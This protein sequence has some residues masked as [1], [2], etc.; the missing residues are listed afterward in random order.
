MSISASSAPSPPSPRP[1]IAVV[2]AGPAG[3]TAAYVLAKAGAQVE[4]HEGSRVV[5]GLSRTLDLWNQRVDL[6]P[7]RFHT[8]DAR[9][10]SL[11][12][13]VVG[14]DWATVESHP[15][16]F[17]NDGKVLRYPLQVVDVVRKVGL[18]ESIRC[19]L[20]YGRQQ[21][22]PLP[23]VRTFEDWLVQHFGRRV[24]E[25]FFRD[26][27]EKFFGRPCSAVDASVS[28]AAAKD[29]SLV[30]TV[31]AALRTGASNARARA[32]KQVTEQF[33]YP[34]RGTGEVYERMAQFVRDHGG[35]VLLESRVEALEVEGRRVTGLKSS[36]GSRAY[37]YIISSAPLVPLVAQLPGQP[38][39]VQRA[40]TEARDVLTF[41]SAL[42]VY[43]EVHETGLFP[44]SWLEMHTRAVRTC[45]VTNFRNW[46]PGLYGEER[47]TIL[48][49][50]YWCS[51]DE[52]LWSE[53]DEAMAA[54]AR[55]ELESVGLLGPAPVGRFH[56]VRLPRCYP[57]YQPGFQRVLQP[58]QEHLDN[59]ERL[60]S[61]GR[62]G[63]FSYN[64]QDA[65][66][67]MGLEAADGARAALGF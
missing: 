1:R 27:N 19:V 13:S 54:L 49:A 63:R 37:D 2:G 64:S 11:W 47:S 30:D 34:Q 17:R 24:Y 51:Q 41:R 28:G 50:E 57:V 42:L 7:H 9:I 65:N 4:V 60:S 58:L 21:L 31:L 3:L 43:L 33:P 18:T 44:E 20:D 56:V 8:Q 67:R 55:K 39:E 22:R 5:G 46:V 59:F 16:V 6:G 26:F 36:H 66:W 35:E 53:S 48:C 29:A 40:L 45:R 52:T 25:Q 32:V 10:D 62:G 61:I 12:K 23:E 14:E 15:G 38:P